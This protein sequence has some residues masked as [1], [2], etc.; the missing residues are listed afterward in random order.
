MTY[1]A[2]PTLSVTCITRI[3]SAEVV[4]EVDDDSGIEFG[5][6]DLRVCLKAI[7]KAR[8]ASSHQHLLMIPFSPELKKKEWSVYALDQS[9]SDRKFSG[10]GT[11]TTV[12]NDDEAVAIVGKVKRRFR[13]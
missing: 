12:L 7:L 5:E 1:K 3:K 2:E 11:I 8:F 13:R 4:K 9:V 6:V 10:N